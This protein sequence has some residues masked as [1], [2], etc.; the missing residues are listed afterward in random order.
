MLYIFLKKFKISICLLTIS[1]KLI[2]S[3]VTNNVCPIKIS[4]IKDST[5]IE[6][7]NTDQKE[8]EIN[9]ETAYSVTCITT[10]KVRKKGHLFLIINDSYT[11]YLSN[12]VESN[13]RHSYLKGQINELRYNKTIET[14]K[15]FCRFLPINPDIYCESEL[16]LTFKPVNNMKRIF[17]IIIIF[18][19]VLV[20]LKLIFRFLPR[21]IVE[22]SEENKVKMEMKPQ[23]QRNNW[24]IISRF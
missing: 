9:L 21:I 24:V 3:N 22:E 16:I 5:K 6:Y 15:L 18:I 12:N 4:L 13:I 19:F 14:Y 20:I 23:V 1:I 17:F 2:N 8:I 11:S 10:E 7:R